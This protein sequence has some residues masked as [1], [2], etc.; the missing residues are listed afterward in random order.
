MKASGRYDERLDA[1]LSDLYSGRFG[2]PVARPHLSAEATYNAAK[3]GAAKRAEAG[4]TFHENL[5]MGNS[6]LLLKDDED[7]ERAMP[8]KGSGGLV[9][10]T[11]HSFP[12]IPVPPLKDRVHKSKYVFRDISG[13]GVA[14]WRLV[15]PLVTADFDGVTRPATNTETLYRSWHTRYWA[16]SRVSK[17]SSKGMPFADADANKARRKNGFKVPR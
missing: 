12:R 14:N 10:R 17:G 11:G 9:L 4:E 7:P 2:T 5:E 16:Q 6:F 13:R 15:N 3:A 8:R 1:Q